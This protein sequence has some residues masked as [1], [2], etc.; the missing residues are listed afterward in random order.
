MLKICTLSSGSDGNCTYITDGKTNILIDAGISSSRIINELGSLGV[1]AAD[2]D[3]IFI[4]H[5]HSDHISG[6]LR[7][8]PRCGDVH[9]Y[10]SCGTK[11]GIEERMPDLRGMAETVYPSDKTYV[12]EIC[13]TPFHTPHDTYESVGYRIEEGG[14]SIVTATDIGHVDSELLPKLCG[15]DL[16]LLEANYDEDR[17][18]RGKYPPFLKSRILGECG[19]LSNDECARCAVSAVKSGTKSVILA[20]LSRENNSPSDA[21][22][23]VH[24][25]LTQSGTIPGVDMM[26]YLAPRGKRGEVITVGK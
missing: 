6:L 5:E 25:A 17:L 9:L 22:K 18:R 3:A 1:G 11:A 20:H 10:A 13:V 12:G 19:H 15:C 7:L 14:A 2:I 8:L 16:L 21:Y 4:T 23:A 26:L 24:S